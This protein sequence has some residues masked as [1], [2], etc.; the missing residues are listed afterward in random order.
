MPAAGP[1]A[2]LRVGVGE[3][4]DGASIRS[5]SSAATSTTCSQPFLVVR[6]RSWV[7]AT[8]PAISESLAFTS[9]SGNVLIDQN[10]SPPG[11]GEPVPFVTSPLAD[12]AGRPLSARRVEAL[13]FSPAGHPNVP[14][15]AG[16]AFAAGTNPMLLRA[17]RR[18][19]CMRRS[20][21]WRVSW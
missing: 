8:S 7:A 4:L 9:D 13:R 17:T 20:S 5:R 3:Q 14:D 1:Q 12:G 16:H 2:V 10:R 19:W 21:G 18:R 11:E 15:E 6:T